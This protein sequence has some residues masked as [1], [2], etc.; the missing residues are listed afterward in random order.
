MCAPKTAPT[1]P[2]FWMRIYRPEDREVAKKWEGKPIELMEK[3]KQAGLPAP[4]ILIYAYDFLDPDADW[5]DFV[6][7][8]DE[9]VKSGKSEVEMMEAIVDYTPPHGYKPLSERPSRNRIV[10]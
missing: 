5:P 4:H 6:K 9:V 10:C 2:D 7:F 3:Y 1:D 8:Y